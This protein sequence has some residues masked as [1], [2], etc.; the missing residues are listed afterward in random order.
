MRL[1]RLSLICRQEHFLNMR[2]VQLS[3]TA[4]GFRRAGLLNME[5]CLMVTGLQANAQ[6]SVLSQYSVTTTPVLYY[7]VDMYG[8]RRACLI[9]CPADLGLSYYVLQST[10]IVLHAETLRLQWAA[11]VTGKGSPSRGVADVADG[12]S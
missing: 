12:P 8:P 10:Q 3:L 2:L 9:A 5:R 7:T 6:R 11:H 1:V 4:R